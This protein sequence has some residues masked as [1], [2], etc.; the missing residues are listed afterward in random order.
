MVRSE[1]HPR[2]LDWYFQTSPNANEVYLIIV[3][4]IF[5][6]FHHP[7][8]A[9]SRCCLLYLVY[10]DVQATGSCGEPEMYRDGRSGACDYMAMSQNRIR[11]APGLAGYWM[12]IPPNMTVIGF[13]T[14]PYLYVHM[15]PNYCIAVYPLTQLIIG[16]TLV[17]RKTGNPSMVA[18]DP[19]IP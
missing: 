11:I 2:P 14:S 13:N 6:Y 15:Y 1:N 7:N 9:F 12:L 17:T 5:W 3:L 16:D 19:P 4:Y 18:A 10:P 8:V